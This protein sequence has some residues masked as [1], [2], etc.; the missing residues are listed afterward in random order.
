MIYLLGVART[1]RTLSETWEHGLSLLAYQ[2]PMLV[3]FLGNLI[4]RPGS[5]VLRN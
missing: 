2:Y 1:P 5:D 3:V 4:P